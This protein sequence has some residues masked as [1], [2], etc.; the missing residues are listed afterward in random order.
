MRS[1]SL[2]TPHPHHPLSAYRFTLSRENRKAVRLLC[3]LLGNL[4]IHI[5]FCWVLRG[6]ASYLATTST[7]GLSPLHW[8]ARQG[9]VETVRVLLDAKAD[10]EAT[11]VSQSEGV[12]GVGRRTERGLRQLGAVGAGQAPDCWSAACGGLLCLDGDGAS[13]GAAGGVRC[14]DALAEQEVSA[15]LRRE[16]RVSM[17]GA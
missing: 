3:N 7:Q 12:G 14:D 13:G 4:H 6:L 17:A 15:A 11:D 16:G 5:R 10:V 8:A 1:S 9:M 2:Y